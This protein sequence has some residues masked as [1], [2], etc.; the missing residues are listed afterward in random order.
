MTNVETQSAQAMPPRQPRWPFAMTIVSLVTFA[1]LVVAVHQF[2]L[3][4]LWDEHAHTRTLGGMLFMSLGLFGLYLPFRLIRQR[5]QFAGFP[6]ARQRFNALGVPLLYALAYAACIG[7]ALQSDTLILPRPFAPTAVV[8]YDG[9]QRFGR[10]T[11]IRF[12]NAIRD[13]LP[14]SG[15]FDHSANTDDTVERFTASFRQIFLGRENKEMGTLDGETRVR[16]DGRA[17]IAINVNAK[18]RLQ[19]SVLGLDDVA[20][21]RDGES[22]DEFD[23][24]PGKYKI[25]IVGRPKN[26]T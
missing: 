8:T 17:E 7:A 25:V 10:Q 5:N 26:G 23:A 24:K 2:A 3:K 1:G 14:G 16:E 4:Y 20:I 12:S 15:G 18:E 13:Q 11:S 19:F 22:I 9:S 6:P 21:T